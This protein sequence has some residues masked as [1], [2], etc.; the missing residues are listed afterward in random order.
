MTAASL[1]PPRS[2]ARLWPLTIAGLVALALVAVLGLALPR[3][4]AQAWLVAFVMWSSVPIGALVLLM[5]HRLTGGE[6]GDALAPALAPLAAMLPVLTIGFVPVALGL[7]FSFAW[8]WQP[9]HPESLDALYLDPA[10]F[11]L[12]GLAMLLGLS[13][14]AVLVLRGGGA[15]LAGVGL[16]FYGLLI[17]PIGVDWVLSLDR[18]YGS[19][20]IGMELAA[21]QMLVALAAAAV[22]GAEPATGRPPRDL[23]GLLIAT[24]LGTVYLGLMT[25]IVDWYGNLPAKAAWY[26]HR[27]DGAW[28]AVL[29]AALA[30]GAVLPMAMLLR[31]SVRSS[32]RTLQWVGALILCGSALHV[33]WWMAPSLSP[34]ALLIVP[35]ALAA[36][37]LLSSAGTGWLVLR[38]R[39]SDG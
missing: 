4:S 7:H 20:A 30:I 23:A 9:V 13:L 12:R 21:Q 37:L 2:F 39:R 8:S 36:L 17:T 24:L 32:R 22:I 10:A 18:G 16:C 33:V 14:L 34:V 35:S 6:W 26:L 5:I 1:P 27:N 25:F 19:S 38:Q 11:A 28:L 3:A 15:L 29:L 31:A